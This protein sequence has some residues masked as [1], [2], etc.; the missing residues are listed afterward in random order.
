MRGIVI[1]MGETGKPLYAILKEAYHETEAYDAKMDYIPIGTFDVLNICIP[2]TDGFI[3]AVSSY[4]ALFNSDVTII[5]STVPIGTTTQITDAVHSPVRG[6]HNRM[7]MDLRRYVKWV[8]GNLARKAV[9]YLEGAG[10]KCN[11]SSTSEETEALKLLCLAKYGK[12]IAFAHYCKQVADA[13][14]FDW[15]YD[16]VYMWDKQ[17]NDIVKDTLRRPLI[18]LNDRKIGGHCVIPNTKIL[19]EQHPNPMLDE[20]L[21]YAN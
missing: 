20:V 11:I 18:E 14:S 17:Y 16:S 2:Y 1:G 19:N 8:G 13:Y 7:E 6:K 9:Q 4:Q 15:G 3:D 12:D 10:F 5:H 21:K